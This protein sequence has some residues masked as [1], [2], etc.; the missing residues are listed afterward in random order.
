MLALK[1][2]FYYLL[3]FIS[4]FFLCE[5]KAQ[6]HHGCEGFNGVG[7]AGPIVTTP[8]YTLLKGTK[9]INTISDYTS[10]NTFPDKK[11][12]ELDKRHE[13]IHD[14]SNLLI[15]SLGAG[16][17]LTDNLTIGLRIPYVFRFGI[18][19]I[20]DTNVGK[21]GNSI[22]IGDITFFSQYRFLKNE[23]HN[24]HAALLTGLKIP[25]GVRR[26]KSNNEEIFEPDEQP[27]SGS[28]DPFVGLALSKKLKYFSL[29]T[30]GLYK[31][32]TNGSQG[33]NLKEQV[34]YN[35]AISHR[36]I[37]EGYLS[38]HKKKISKKDFCMDLIVEAN[39]IWSQK[40][41]T[42]HGF[43]DENH[44]GNIIYLSPGFRVTFDK[45]WIWTTSAGLPTIESLNGRQRAPHIRLITGIAKVF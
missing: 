4:I 34:N 23:K 7:I 12:I 32:S 8:A 3:I 43:I 27:G 39:G 28:W 19:D 33:S 44:G 15:Q 35:L 9:Y 17:G 30:N 36:L 16:Y 13:H 25:S 18:K 24:I 2:V 10:F 21:G 29:D 1:L 38:F 5:S 37:N 11:L 31:F 40:P 22:G 6:A 20:H 41:N 45:K 42:F 26:T 14:T